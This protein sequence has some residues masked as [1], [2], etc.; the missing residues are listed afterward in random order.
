M[1][2]GLVFENRNDVSVESAWAG[3]SFSFLKVVSE[4]KEIL[5]EAAA[6]AL[7]C[8]TL[9]PPLPWLLPSLPALHTL[10][11]DGRGIQD[12]LGL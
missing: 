10:R 5:A 2:A 11:R 8:C 3:Y 7:T 1:V 6:A 4:L 12:G 9:C